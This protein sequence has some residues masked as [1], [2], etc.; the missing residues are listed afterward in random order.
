MEVVIAI[1]TLNIDSEIEIVIDKLLSDGRGMGR[2][3]GRVV[4]VDGVIPGEAVRLRVTRIKS[5]FAEGQLLQVVSASPHRIAPFC[6]HFSDCGGCSLQYLE[7]GA[8]LRHKAEAL[9]DSLRRLGKLADNELPALQ[10][11][12]GPEHGYRNRMR[13]IAH[14]DGGWG[15]RGKSSR[16]VVLLQECR[17][18]HPRIQTDLLH[19]R[20]PDGVQPGEEFTVY[21]DDHGLY[22]SPHQAEAHLSGLVF[23]FPVDS[24]FQSNRVML[25]AVLPAVTEDL[26]DGIV[27]DLYGGMGVF[28]AGVARHG[29]DC[30]S[31]DS[32]IPTG[33]G[34]VA[35]PDSDRQR[36]SVVFRRMKVEQW[37][38]TPEAAQ[39]YG[40]V[41]LD[42]PRAGLSPAVCRGV[43][44][45]DTRVIRYLSCNPDTFARDAGH[46]VRSGRRL[47][48]L[49]TV[50]FYPHSSHLEV[51]GE[52][53]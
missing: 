36:G 47:T 44:R 42:P 23:R 25:E 51:F 49:L 32:H 1:G 39:T 3:Q 29:H 6:Q 11:L 41:L 43:C 45:M 4:F 15:L 27:A 2:F 14:R 10:L 52:F 38:Q 28:A 16:R 30:I 17:I 19:G 22:K 7:A 20:I 35:S 50:D 5:G 13:F 21:A 12:H 18:A 31:V 46:L 48:R 9:R 8:Q 33:A 40:A 34:V 37:L 53:R 26:P 24:F